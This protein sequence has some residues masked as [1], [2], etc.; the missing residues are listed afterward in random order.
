M[1][2]FPANLTPAELPVT[3]KNSAES[4]V[5]GEYCNQV[6][7]SPDLIR[8]IPMFPVPPSSKMK[9]LNL[10]HT[11]TTEQ[12]PAKHS[13]AAFQEMSAGFSSSSGDSII[14]VA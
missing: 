13:T 8:P 6:N 4:L 7:N 10:N 5:L 2:A 3:G 9:E 12:P 1:E 11:A 14:S